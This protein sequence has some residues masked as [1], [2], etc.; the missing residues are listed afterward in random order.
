MIVVIVLWE[1]AVKVFDVK[2]YILPAPSQVLRKL[3]GNLSLLFRY[4]LVTGWEILLGYL[5]SIIVGIPMGLMIFYSRFLERVIYPF[6]VASQTIPKIAIAPLLIIWFGWGIWPKIIVSFLIAFFPI[7]VDTVV[8]LKNT[9]PEM[10]YLVR[11]MGADRS[12]IFF[13]ISLPNALPNIFGA[14]KVASTL[15]VVGAV[16]GEFV[17]SD[18]GLGY[19][20]V[21]SHGYMD[22]TL[23]FAGILFLSLLGIIFFFIIEIIE[24]LALP[25]KTEKESVLH[26]ATM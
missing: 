23:M 3:T 2:E 22:T 13:K 11:S 25:W 18:E 19:L 24:R 5:L 14:L 9:E 4:S 16:V 1:L 26:S 12:Q 15:A 6:L 8:G 17:A 21:V 7:V 10:I 20:L